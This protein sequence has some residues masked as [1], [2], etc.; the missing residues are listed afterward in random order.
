MRFLSV[1]L[2]VYPGAHRSL[3]RSLLHNA[4]CTVTLAFAQAA[5]ESHDDCSRYK[6]LWI[7]AA[8]RLNKL[9]PRKKKI[10]TR[11]ASYAFMA[12]QGSLSAAEHGQLGHLM[13]LTTRMD[14]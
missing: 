13:K 5:V 6:K 1:W 7:A 4:H 9:G 11:V 3:P 14:M 8:K 10:Y 2:L 12:E